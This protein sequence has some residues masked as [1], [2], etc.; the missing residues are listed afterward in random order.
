MNLKKFSIIIPVYN[1]ENVISTTLQSVIN[2]Y[3]YY[4]EYEIIII[5]DGSI[6]NS[7]RVINDVIEKNK[8]TN[9]SIK[10]FDTENQGVSCARNL[11]IEK[12][13]GD[14]IKNKL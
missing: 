7:K 3:N 14:Y 2:Q 11:G 4:K 8:K 12:A 10:V 6:D 5:N 1:A 13:N 9:I